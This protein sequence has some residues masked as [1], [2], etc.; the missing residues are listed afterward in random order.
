MSISTRVLRKFTENDLAQYPAE[1]E[2]DVDDTPFSGGA[3]KKQLNVNRFDLLNQQSES[4]SESEVKEDDDENNQELKSK[5][6]GKSSNRESTKRKKK[7]KRKKG[8][9]NNQQQSSD[10]V[11]E[12]ER[13]IQEVNAVLGD[14]AVPHEVRENNLR[15]TNAVKEILSVKLKH[16]NPKT[17]LKRIFG[18]KIVKSEQSKRR[19]H[20]RRILKSTWL[21]TPKDHWP[22]ITK[23]GLS[24]KLLETKNDI[25]YFTYEHSLNYQSVQKKFLEAVESM[26]PDNIMM[27]ANQSPNHVDTMIQLSDIFKLSDDL[28]M[29]AELIERAIYS[30]ESAFH[31]L[32][33]VAKGNCRLDYKRQENRAL[34]IALFKH[35]TFVGQRACYR[36]A[37]EFCKL[38]FSLDPEK[39]PL[40]IVLAIDFYALRSREFDWFLKFIDHLD[41]EKNLSQL[42]NIVFSKALALFH[43]SDPSSD[44]ALQDALLM[45][46]SMLLPLLENCSIQPDPKT[47]AHSYFNNASSS[48]TPALNLLV[49]LYVHRNYHIWKEPD[50]LSWLE[51]NT[52]AVLNRVDNKDPVV[53]DYA[54]KRSRR[55]EAKTPREI[56]R[57]VFLSDIKQ[58][59]TVL[60]ET[61]NIG[62]TFSFDPLPPL[63]SVNIYTRPERPP[64]TY[65]NSN[66]FSLYFRSIMP[67]FNAD[68][69]A[70]P[71]EGLEVE[72]YD[73]AANNLESGVRNLLDVMR[74][75]LWNYQY[76]RN[77][78]EGAAEGS[79]SS[80]ETDNNDSTTTESPL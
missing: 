28:Q 71:A 12:V 16:L 72:L 8:L 17:E 36:T 23:L 5:H 10:D 29:A 25:Q 11:D 63:D 22:P 40:A 56:E 37:L 76:D 3:K 79:G 19:S 59:M 53:L 65:E 43:L 35:L 74:N 64:R 32:F 26:Y 73:E 58:V 50:T 49:H 1:D 39:D 70:N 41:H 46:P 4:Q 44:A 14:T 77:E 68:A 75:M 48:R 80:N 18:S 24:M 55:F 57:H 33:N 6:S 30:L 69:V 66:P 62:T 78:V 31:P 20:G 47:Q 42:P 67:D 2:S 27:V 13:S 54:Q 21:V 61:S 7:K 60:A 38:I 34:Y 45:F 52:L 15:S 9:K 51:K